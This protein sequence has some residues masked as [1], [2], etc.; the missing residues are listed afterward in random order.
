MSGW[1]KLLGVL[2]AVVLGMIAAGCAASEA[3]QPRRHVVEI[4][5]FGYL[6]SRLD[7]SPGD[8]VVWVN[9]DV[10]PHTA[11]SADGSWDSGSIEAG[12]TWE[13]IAAEDGGGRYICAFHPTMEGEVGVE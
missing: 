10:V 2:A 13:W 6:P 8:T 5:G 9:R 7:V 11:T 3:E 1:T 4:S 12:G